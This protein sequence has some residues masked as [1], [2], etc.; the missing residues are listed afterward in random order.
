MHLLLTVGFPTVESGEINAQSQ[1]STEKGTSMSEIPQ[2]T[3]AASTAELLTQVTEAVRPAG[4]CLAGRFSTAARTDGVEGILA[5]L[6]ANDDAVLDV[7]RAPLLAARPGSG[8]VED[9]LEGGPLPAGEWWVVDP[10]EGNINHIHGLGE[11]AV[12]ATLVRDN[13]PVLTVV[14]LPLTGDTYTALAGHGARL[15]GTPLRPSAKTV[16]AAALVGTGQARP[17]ETGDTHRR[18]GESVTAMLDAALV[19]RVSVPATLQLIHVAAG[20]TDAFWQYSDVRSGLLA[21]ALLVQEAGG[22]VSDTHGRPWSLAAGDFLAT[23]PALH[24][25]AVGVLSAVR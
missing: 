12:T 2:S 20:R 8:W 25:A 4:R 13:T 1:R 9:E 7:L 23:A 24:A 6:A 16:L 3:A 17:G 19:V 11:W 14:H 22:T 5:A 18:I 15:N 10:A 21:G